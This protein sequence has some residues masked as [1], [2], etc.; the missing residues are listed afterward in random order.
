MARAWLLL[1]YSVPTKPSRTR[2]HVWRELRRVG[3][4]L[5]RDG[6]AILPETPT[7]RTWMRDVATGIAT[8][9][10]SA[11][12]ARARFSLTE[13]RDILRNFER[14]RSREY[15][16][17]VESC[18]GL[19]EHVDREAEHA[20]FTF[21]ELAELEADLDKLRRWNTA[22]GERDR[23]RSPSAARAERVLARCERKIARFADRT[24]RVEGAAAPRATRKARGR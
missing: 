20:Q 16:E 17:I 5:L 3:A 11:Q 18:R 23:F 8:G 4:I 7:V 24:S 10:G 14:D 2:W 15:D 22:A 13:E 19:L 6:V 1:I 9:G 21:A 12:V